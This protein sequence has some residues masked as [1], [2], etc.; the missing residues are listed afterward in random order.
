MRAD[1]ILAGLLFGVFALLFYEALG[2]RWQAAIGPLLATGAGAVLTGWIAGQGL[3]RFARGEAAL[4]VYEAADLLPFL[5]FLLAVL[6]VVLLGFTLGGSLYV[7]GYILVT[8]RWAFGRALIAGISVALALH[9]L[10][11]LGL[12]TPLFDGLLLGGRAWR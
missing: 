8:M 11:E 6:M 4:S 1:T 7:A 2:F 12:G 10:I 5:G 9:L 3:L